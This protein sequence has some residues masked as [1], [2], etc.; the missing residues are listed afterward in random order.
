MSTPPVGSTIRL[1]DAHDGGGAAVAVAAAHVLA[2]VLAFEDVESL[3]TRCGIAAP[4]TWWV[5]AR[6]AR[7]D[8]PSCLRAMPRP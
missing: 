5:M 4:A 6:G 1:A 8:C 2:R 7:P 3:E